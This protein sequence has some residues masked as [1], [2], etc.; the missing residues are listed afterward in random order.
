MDR[1]RLPAKPTSLLAVS[2]ALLGVGVP[3]IAIARG[4]VVVSSVTESPDTRPTRGHW[5]TTITVSNQGASTA[6]SVRVRMF[7]ST[8]R[9]FSR[10]DIPRE[11]RMTPA[12]VR[13]YPRMG[14]MRVWPMPSKQRRR[15]LPGANWT[16][17]SLWSCGRPAA[18]PRRT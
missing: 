11:L 7:L 9:R 2:A 8:G 12:T 1:M 5:R 16:T 13:I 4:N 17:S 3:A 6:S 10:D 18:A 14:S 15:K